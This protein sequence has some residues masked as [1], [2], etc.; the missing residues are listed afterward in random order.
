MLPQD[1]KEDMALDEAVAL[2]VKV[3]SKTMDSTSLSSDKVELATL[4]L[5]PVTGHVVYHVY[6]PAEM[7]PLLDARNEEKQKEAEEAA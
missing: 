3:L 4:M 7:Q 1:F 2:A 6:S 5:H